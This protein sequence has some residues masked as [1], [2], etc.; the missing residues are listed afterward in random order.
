MHVY[1]YI[2]V[3]PCLLL[4]YMY[5]HSDPVEREREGKGTLRYGE[6]DEDERTEAPVR[7]GVHG[8]L[9]HGAG[10]SRHH[11]RHHVGALPRPR[12]MLSRHFPHRPPTSANWG[13]DNGDDATNWETFRCVWKEGPADSTYDTLHFPSGRTTKFFYAYYVLRTITSMVSEGSSQC[14][15]LAYVADNIAEARRATAFGIL[16]GLGSAAFVCGTL[17]AHFLST[18]Q[19]FQVAAFM[20]MAATVYMR[21]FLKDS[22]QENSDDLAQPILKTEENSSLNEGE[23]SSSVQAFKKF[24]SVGDIICLLKSRVTFSQ[25]A[26]V[27]LFN[28]LAEGGLQSSTMYFFKAE[29]HYNKDQFADL[30]LIGGVAGT[31]SQ[32]LFMP[33]LAPIVGEEKLLS[34]GLLVGASSMLLNSIAW[35]SWVPYALGVFSIFAVLT[36]PCL[37][38]IVS[39]QVGPNEQGMAHG[40]ISAISSFSNI[41]SPFI[42]SPLT[43][44]FLSQG[45][46]FHFPGFSLMC[47]GL[48]TMM[49]FIVSLMIRAAPPVPSNAGSD[50]ECREA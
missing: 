16:S 45:A 25:V 21:I 1:I 9:R 39:K 41:L 49:A 44:L 18:A 3:T 13:R 11:R 50:S 10:D 23:P 8:Q 29:F 12:P 14:L 38:S 33:M 22:P 2:R 4:T 36:N 37:R 43:A 27:V 17:T 7:D 46:P 35:S 28:S 31:V 30:M 42:F 48:A 26:I 47:A 6:D 19:T 24:P 32:L 5:T 20:S 40:C 15:A 34:L